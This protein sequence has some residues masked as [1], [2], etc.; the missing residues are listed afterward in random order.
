MSH[1]DLLDFSLLFSVD[2]IK[3]SHYVGN[4]W[5]SHVPFSTRQLWHCFL[6]QE[7]IYFSLQKK[8]SSYPA[9]LPPRCRV[10]DNTII[11]QSDFFHKALKLIISNS[12]DKFS[13]LLISLSQNFS[14]PKKCCN[15]VSLKNASR[16]YSR[17]VRTH[18]FKIFTD[19]NFYAR[20]R[21]L[22]ISARID[23][24]T[25]QF[26]TPC[27][28]AANIPFTFTNIHL[29]VAV[30]CKPHELTSSSRILKTQSVPRMG[31]VTTMCLSCLYMHHL[32]VRDNGTIMHPIW[33]L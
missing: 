29:P 6:H 9:P 3:K 31:I 23:F 5:D 32:R 18:V 7:N 26:L 2:V 28:K 11:L 30:P 15:P 13:P 19:L 14:T 1:T 4:K 20:L 10:E 8:K 25:C 21:A 16:K 17:I 33:V 27:S 22:Y 24:Y 12:Y